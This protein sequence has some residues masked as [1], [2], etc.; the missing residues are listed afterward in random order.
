MTSL[1]DLPDGH[2][3]LAPLPDWVLAAVPYDDPLAPVARRL[4]NGSPKRGDQA[5][6]G[7]W[8]AS[9][10]QFAVPLPG[11]AEMP[12]RPAE[13]YGQLMLWDAA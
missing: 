13:H 10:P 9:H 8:L 4:K 3:I 11:G 5:A 2:Y 12:P 7:E 6:M 1:S